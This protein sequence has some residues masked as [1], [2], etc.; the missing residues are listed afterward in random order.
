MVSMAT[1]GGGAPPL[2]PAAAGPGASPL[3][4]PRCWS[5]F[6]RLDLPEPRGPT[7]RIIA[8]FMRQGWLLSSDRWAVLIKQGER[9]KDVL[10]LEWQKAFYG[11]NGFWVKS[12][13]FV[14]GCARLFTCWLK[15]LRIKFE[16]G[17]QWSTMI[18]CKAKTFGGIKKG[19]ANSIHNSRSTTIGSQVDL[20]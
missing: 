19:S 14:T 8:V 12:L 13:G 7:H 9:S 3:C 11:K 5:A 20:T 18:S 10:K 16:F 2:E 1:A 6:K 4:R 17:Q 15:K